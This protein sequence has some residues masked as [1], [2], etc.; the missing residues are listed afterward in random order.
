MTVGELISRLQDF[1]KNHE[2]SF[3]D[4]YDDI[5]YDSEDLS[6]DE[7]TDEVVIRLN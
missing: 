6:F 3:Y 1:N 7:E 5:S 2:V 4:N